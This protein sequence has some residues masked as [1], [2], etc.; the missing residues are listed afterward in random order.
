MD[1]DLLVAALFTTPLSAE[2][3]NSCQREPDVVTTQSPLGLPKAPPPR[4]RAR[5]PA[6]AILNKAHT[7]QRAIEAMNLPSQNQ[8]SSF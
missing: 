4:P 3:P 2:M 8:Q 5:A 1:F 6:R 7:Q